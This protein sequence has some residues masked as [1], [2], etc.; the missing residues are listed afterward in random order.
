MFFLIRL[1]AAIISP[2][3]AND[4]WKMVQ[5]LG[6]MAKR[7]ALTTAEALVQDSDCIKILGEEGGEL[8]A[9]LFICSGCLAKDLNLSVLMEASQTATESRPQFR[10]IPHSNEDNRC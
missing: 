9:Q 7:G 3:A 5:M 8:M 4:V 6:G 2:D 1:S 10:S